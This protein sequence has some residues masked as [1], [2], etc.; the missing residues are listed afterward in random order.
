MGDWFNIRRLLEPIGNILPARAEAKHD[1]KPEDPAAA[2]VSL[3]E[4]HPRKARC[5]LPESLKGP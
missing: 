3:K 1:A 2:R 4:T 5:G